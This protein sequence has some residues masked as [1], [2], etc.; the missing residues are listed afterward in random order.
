VFGQPI[1]YSDLLA[2][3]PRPTLYKKAA[4]RFMRVVAELGAREKE[5]RAQCERDELPD[6]DVRWLTTYRRVHAR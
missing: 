2:E 6:D 1:D 3:K 4:D 5:L